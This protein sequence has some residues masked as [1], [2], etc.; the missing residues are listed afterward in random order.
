MYKYGLF[1][2]SVSTK[3]LLCKQCG[4]AVHIMDRKRESGEHEF[5]GLNICHIMKRA[6]INENIIGILSIY[7]MKIQFRI[8]L[9]LRR[10]TF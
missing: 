1:T 8:D 4:V 9:I 7:I 10:M 2:V 5:F 3:Q 6:K